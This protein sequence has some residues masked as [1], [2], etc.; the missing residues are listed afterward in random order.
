MFELVGMLMLAAT[1]WLLKVVT[2]AVK[3]ISAIK[4]DP[5]KAFILRFILACLS[6]VVASLHAMLSG[7]P[8]PDDAISMFV[9]A[10]KLF[11]EAFIFWLATTG[12]YK[13]GK[14]G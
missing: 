11:V 9:D 1:P 2:N 3:A 5:A 10:T 12:L 8:V 6:I 4:Y 7:T 14:K 13:L